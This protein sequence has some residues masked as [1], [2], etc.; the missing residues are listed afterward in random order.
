MKIAPYFEGELSVSNDLF[1]LIE[2]AKIFSPV[3]ATPNNFESL[4]IKYP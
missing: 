4:N 3:N 1:Q 2:I